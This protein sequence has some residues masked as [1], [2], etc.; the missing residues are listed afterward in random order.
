MASVQHSVKQQTLSAIQ[1]TKSVQCLADLPFDGV[2]DL[3]SEIRHVG[4]AGVYGW[5]WEWQGSGGWRFAYNHDKIAL[6]W[7]LKA[8]IE[9]VIFHDRP[10]WQALDRC[11]LLESVRVARAEGVASS[12]TFCCPDL[13]ILAWRGKEQHLLEVHL[14]SSTPD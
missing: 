7:T 2:S 9:N 4:I 8:A 6:T 14:S 12:L 11:G 5:L 10:D 1:R 3:L 13:L